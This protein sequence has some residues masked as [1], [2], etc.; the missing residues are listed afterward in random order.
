MSEPTVLKDGTS[1]EPVQIGLQSPD[2]PALDATSVKDYLL[3][4]PDFF[5][6]YPLLA[7]QLTIPHSKRG[8]VSLVELQAEQLREKV[9]ELQIQISQ[10]MTVAKQNEKIYRI[11]AD[12][13]LKLLHCDSV[14]SI[15]ATLEESIQEQLDLAA[16]T[17]LSDEQNQQILDDVKAK[18]LSKQPFFFGRL[19]QE[20]NS[21][22]FGDKAVESVA[23]MPLGEDGNIGIL[24]IGSKNAEHFFPDM[25][26]LLITQLQQLLSLLIPK[27]KG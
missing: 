15:L 27:A 3:A 8:T 13:N 20:E 11:Y 16:V 22:L 9:K 24:A 6:R 7:E 19:T 5:Y 18:R 2:L 14:E 4:N 23:L 10:L 25:D 1:S 12:L 26:T 21:Q 17:M